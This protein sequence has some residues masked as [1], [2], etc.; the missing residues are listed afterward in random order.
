MGKLNRIFIVGLPG[1][2]KALVAKTLAEKLGWNFIN[3]DFGIEIHA[4]RQLEQIISKE[5]AETF[6]KFQAEL[7]DDLIDKKNNIVVMTD[8]SIIDGK[9]NR[10]ILSQEFV[11]FLQVSIPTHIERA[12]RMPP[13]FLPVMSIEDFLEKLHQERD[14]FYEQVAS[15]TINTDDSCLEKHVQIILDYV[16]EGQATTESYQPKLD[17]K[18]QVIFHRILH[19]PITLSEQ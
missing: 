17:L 6:Y 13:P 11:V 19:V 16:R 3:A 12:S 9:E 1:V 5:G 10:K 2:G 7:L 4:G 18:D 15:L 14:Q 8:A